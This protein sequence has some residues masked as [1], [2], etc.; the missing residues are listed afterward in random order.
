[1]EQNVHHLRKCILFSGPR[2]PKFYVA[3]TPN[4]SPK[5]NSSTTTFPADLSFIVETSDEDEGE[6]TVTLADKIGKVV[7]C[8]FPVKPFKFRKFDKEVIKGVPSQ[9]LHQFPSHPLKYL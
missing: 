9:V 8:K 4:A 5:S 3:E 7:P 6:T 2:V 1:M